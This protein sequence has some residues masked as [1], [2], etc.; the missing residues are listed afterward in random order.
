[1]VID[2]HKNIDKY[3]SKLS[4]IIKDKIKLVKVISMVRI[5][6]NMLFIEN[7]TNEFNKNAKKIKNKIKSNISLPDQSSQDPDRTT[8]SKK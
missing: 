8:F 2:K 4:L 7:K 1:M 6:R 3:V 5:H